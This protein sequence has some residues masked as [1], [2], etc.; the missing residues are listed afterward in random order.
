MIKIVKLHVGLFRYIKTELPKKKF[1]EGL[2]FLTSLVPIYFKELS[3]LFKNLFLIFDKTYR[4]KK[5]QYDKMQKIRVELDRALK[6]L[7]YIDKKMREAGVP[8]YK[9]RQFW[10]DFIKD[11]A[12]RKDVFDDLLKD[13]NQIKQEK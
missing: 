13:I 1:K 10:R 7:N 5:K 2:K 4:E 3:K 12:V 6:L 11:G 8:R 9:V